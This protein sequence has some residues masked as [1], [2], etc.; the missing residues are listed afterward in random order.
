MAEG[1]HAERA[2]TGRGVGHAWGKSPVT[3]R[4][5]GLCWV[6]VVF[7]VV[8][9]VSMHGV[10]AFGG[11]TAGYGATVGDQIAGMESGSVGG[12]S[13]NTSNASG[14]S[15]EPT[16]PTNNTSVRVSD[17]DDVVVPIGGVAGQ[18]PWNGTVRATV[19]NTGD[20]RG[21]T[22]VDVLVQPP[23]APSATLTDRTRVTLDAGEAQRISLQPI[24][25]ISG[26]PGNY[27]VRVS[28]NDSETEATI[29]VYFRRYTHFQL[30]NVSAEGFETGDAG[31]LV[32]PV[33]NTGRPPDAGPDLRPSQGPATVS[34]AVNG[35]IV[36]EQR[37]WLEVG[38]S[39][40][41]S[42]SAPLSAFAPGRNEVV[43]RIGAT[44]EPEIDDRVTFTVANESEQTDGDTGHGF[45]TI[46]AAL[47]VGAG[48]GIRVHRRH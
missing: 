1:V 24:G 17:L 21:T 2:R 27:T 32:V 39:E 14:T 23:G 4:A 44:G 6:G 3:P 11:E 42:L 28:A 40:T 41:V 20:R 8:V 16:T 22:W 12:A 30:G 5:V 34:V 36:A 29:A 37:R 26:G 31:T 46:V 35:V 47:G 18:T 45:G 15:S 7:L 25:V 10:V 38:E 13:A 19:T 33:E 48:I 43:V 9:G